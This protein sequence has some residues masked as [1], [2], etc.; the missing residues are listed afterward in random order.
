MRKCKLRYKINGE[1][2][3]TYLYYKNDISEALNNFFL[4]NDKTKVDIVSLQLKKHYPDD[5]EIEEK[6]YYPDDLAEYI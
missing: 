2:K 6:I 4:F 5:M 3:V 1:E